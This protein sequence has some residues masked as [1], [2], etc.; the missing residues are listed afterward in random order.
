MT[1]HNNNQPLIRINQPS[2]QAEKPKMQ[3]IFHYRKPNRD[4]INKKKTKD[5]FEDQQTDELNEAT[6]KEIVADKL[7]FEIIE[8]VSQQS[9]NFTLF[10]LTQDPD[11]LI[12]N[13]MDSISNPSS[14]FDLNSIFNS[15]EQLEKRIDSSS[16]IKLKIEQNPNLIESISIIE[17]AQDVL[18]DILKQQQKKIDV[19][20]IE[21][22]HPLDQ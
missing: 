20:E 2:F 5:E 8:P 17:M 22:I 16:E 10:D 12:R 7:N 6:E 13:L 21:S 1:S 15:G 19:V 11:L 14:S 4:K 9:T 3:T 18:Q